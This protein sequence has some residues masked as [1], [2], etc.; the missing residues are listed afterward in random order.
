MLRLL[1]NKK[2]AKW[3]WVILA[4]IIVPA[5][6]LWGSGSLIRSKDEPT[7]AGRI[8]G[9]K[10]SFLDYRDALEAVKNQAIIQYGEEFSQKQLNLE[11][12]V[13][14]RLILLAEAKK[15][16]IKVSD[17][18]VVGLIQSYPFFQR[19]GK[20]DNRTYSQMLEYVFRT[21]ARIFE[22]Q[23]RQNIMLSKLY[24]VVT[25]DINL[26]DEEIKEAYR[27]ENEEISIYYIAGLAS[28]FSKEINPTDQE[29]KDYFTQNSLEFKMP[30]SF[31]MEYV[32]VDSEEKTKDI[33]SYL[34]KHKKEDFLKVAKDFGLTLQE[35]GWFGQTDPIPHIGWSPDILNIISKAKIGEF[36]PP[37][38][39]DKNY[40]ILRLKEKKEPY[41]PDFE[42]IKDK[43]KERFTNERS[44]NLAKEKEENCL[45]KLKENYQAN[46]KSVDFERA[47]KE[48]GLKSDSTS[49]FKY[50]SYIEGI[51]AS[52][53][54]WM[55]ASGLNDGGFSEIINAPSGFYIIKLKS[56]TPID[57][58]KFESEKAE[59]TQKLLLLKKQEYFAKFAEDLKRG[60]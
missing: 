58:K 19:K 51:G 29:L 40:S 50:G 48:Y 49:P 33:V 28:D 34:Q 24:N 12:D 26:R 15:H 3:I 25:K 42:S 38:K 4:I 39:M 43:V 32:T 36:L 47:A 57:E 2:I 11:S 17:K 45:K 46:P 1:R 8:F 37:I 10:I 14:Y 60:S 44:Q 56:K 21:P 20:F 16:N 27:K 35:T 41:I 7:Y 52:D 5:F 53:E 23:S 6:V 30:L 54:F 13:W 9:K 59:F 18:E 55:A 31:N 22:E